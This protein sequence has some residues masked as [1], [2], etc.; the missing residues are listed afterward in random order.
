ME[1]FNTFGEKQDFLSRLNRSEMAA[2]TKLGVIK[3][4]AAGNNPDKTSLKILNDAD[5]LDDQYRRS[6]Q[7][8]KRRAEYRN[9]IDNLGRAESN[10]DIAKATG[11]YI[12]DT[13]THP[14]EW[15]VAGAIGQMINPLEWIPGK[16]GGTA[17][18]VLSSAAVGAANEAA[19]AYAITKQ[20]GGDAAKDA[21]IAALVGLGNGINK[22][23]GVTKKKTI[24]KRAK[25]KNDTLLAAD[26]IRR[27]TKIEPDD[28]Y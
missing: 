28:I 21:K 7:S 22:E 23:T 8:T 6:R 12:Y 5:S 19:Q 27:I 11:S 13:V 17:T 14:S 16:A 1:E 10:M 15:N 4:Y 25:A 20:Q 9:V 2:L 26:G 3:D 24:S 18:R